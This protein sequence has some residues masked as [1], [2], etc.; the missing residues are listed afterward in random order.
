MF[1]CFTLLYKDVIRF[2]IDMHERLA[3][4]FSFAVLF[5][6]KHANRENVSFA[7]TLSLCVQLWTVNII[8]ETD[9]EN[10][11]NNTVFI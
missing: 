4:V 3:F 6:Q 1:A 8:R 5:R 9:S 2:K 7:V 10:N 11:E